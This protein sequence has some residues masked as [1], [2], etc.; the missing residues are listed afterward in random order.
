[1]SRKLAV[2]A[3]ILALTISGFMGCSNQEAELQKEAQLNA[4]MQRVQE[5]IN[6]NDQAIAGLEMRLQILEEDFSD[7]AGK[8]R[9]EI[10][11][12][13]QSN[14][15]L[16]SAITGA[17]VAAVDAQAPAAK[18][19]SGLPGWLEFVL[20][21]VI[22]VAALLL[23]LYLLRPKPVEDEDFEDFEDMEDFEMDESNAGDAGNDGDEKKE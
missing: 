4:Q 18:A 11:K 15:A 17:P 20:I 3:V 7:N 5:Q 23:L 16:R 2:F 12:V 14:Q 13:K 22:I 8:V 6:A 1:M 21:L 9:A 10:L 19:K